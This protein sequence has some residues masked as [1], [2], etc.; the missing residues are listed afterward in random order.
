MENELT[1]WLEY[2]E[3]PQSSP[4]HQCEATEQ[5]ALA[6]KVIRRL[7]YGVTCRFDYTLSDPYFSRLFYC[8]REDVKEGQ[9]VA[10]K[11]LRCGQP[12]TLTSPVPQLATCGY[13]GGLLHVQMEGGDDDKV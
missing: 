9:R 13:C 4:R 3:R 12:H 11:C 1:T 6:T 8:A 7:M 2:L 10:L 5:L